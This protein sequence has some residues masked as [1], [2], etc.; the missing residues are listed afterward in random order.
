MAQPSAESIIYTPHGLP[1]TA[2]S[3]LQQA[4]PPIK[5]LCLIH[6]LHDV[7]ISWGQQLN[8]GAKNAVKAMEVLKAKYWVGTH[9]EVKRGGG[10]VSWVLNRKVLGWKEAVQEVLGEQGDNVRFEELGNGESRV[11]M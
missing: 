11:L 8:L 10:I 9:D 5:C 6:G 7:S 1:P 2:L 4:N 3:P